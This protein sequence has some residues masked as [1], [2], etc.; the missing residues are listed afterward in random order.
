M[1]VG[2][3]PPA[4]GVAAALNAPYAALVSVID[5]LAAGG[6]AADADKQRSLT[7]AGTMALLKI[8]VRKEQK[9]PAPPAWPSCVQ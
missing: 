3:P 7:A 1:A 2:E 6:A 8:K 9:H 5:Q 4:A